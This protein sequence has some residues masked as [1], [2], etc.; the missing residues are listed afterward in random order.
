ME[1]LLRKRVEGRS[2]S[3]AREK[4][5]NPG[6]SPSWQKGTAAVRKRLK[7]VVLCQE[8]ERVLGERNIGRG[9]SSGG[10]VN[11]G[12]KNTV[13]HERPRVKIAPREEKVPLLYHEGGKRPH[14]VLTN[15]WV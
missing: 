1:T 9:A 3:L 11:G 14:Q 13:R 12:G 10:D 7:F 5:G 6:V 8:T 15:K 2:P 4:S